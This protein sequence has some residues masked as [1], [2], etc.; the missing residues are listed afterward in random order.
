[1]P[2]KI[3][4]QSTLLLIKTKATKEPHVVAEIIKRVLYLGLKIERME[5][6]RQS[7][8]TTEKVKLHNANDDMQIAGMG[9]KCMANCIKAGEKPIDVYKTEDPILIG[10][11]INQKNFEGLSS[12][13]LIGLVISGENAIKAVRKLLGYTFPI[14]AN[15]GTVRGDFST[16]NGKYD[17]YTDTVAHA[18]DIVDIDAEPN[19]REEEI[20]EREINIWFPSYYKEVELE[21][22]A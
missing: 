4:I 9:K 2:K 22:A 5:Y 14:E 11:F 13:D 16:T 21:E 1:M 17:E 7:K 20:A 19:R 10:K 15:V 6:F 3:K 18:S 8:K 12:G